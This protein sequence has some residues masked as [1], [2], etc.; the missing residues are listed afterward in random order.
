MKELKESRSRL[1]SNGSANLK[2][3]KLK[4]KNVQKSNKMLKKDKGLKLKDKL[5]KINGKEKVV[6][7]KLEKSKRDLIMKDRETWNNG[8]LKKIEKL[9]KF[10]VHKNLEDQ[11]LNHKLDGE[12]KIKSM[13]LNIR[14]L[15]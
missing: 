14:D 13:K 3:K 8:K 1:E 2:Q 12:E 15:F 11:K 9:K 5:K 6:Y 7:R 4:D 10:N